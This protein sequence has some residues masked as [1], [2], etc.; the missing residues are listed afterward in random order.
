MHRSLALYPLFQ[1]PDLQGSGGGSAM[2]EFRRRRQKLQKRWRR[3]ES[4]G[5]NFYHEFRRWPSV[6]SGFEC[7][8][9]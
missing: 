7:R 6:N 3:E 9:K 5:S 4:S 2:H 8:A 1:L